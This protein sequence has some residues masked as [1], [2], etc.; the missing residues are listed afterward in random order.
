[1]FDRP[2]E[3]PMDLRAGLRGEG[4]KGRLTIEKV[5]VCVLCVLEMLLER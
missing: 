1:M 4:E 5:C 2:R 3:G